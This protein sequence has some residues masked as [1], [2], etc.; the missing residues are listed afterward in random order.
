MVQG[1]N[2]TN[3][4]CCFCGEKT[5]CPYGN[6]PAPIADEGKCCGKCN[7]MVIIARIG[8][9]SVEDARKQLKILSNIRLFQ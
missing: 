1:H 6:N 2:T 7:E 3:P 8:I 4:I 9:V 5:E